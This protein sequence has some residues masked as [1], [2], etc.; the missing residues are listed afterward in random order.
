MENNKCYKCGSMDE[1]FINAEST[2]QTNNRYVCE[3]C[4]VAG[5]LPTICIADMV[6]GAVP[7]TVY[8]I[9]V[10]L[11]K[12]TKK[13]IINA[14]RKLPIPDN[15]PAI[16][17]IFDHDPMTIKQHLEYL[18]VAGYRVIYQLVK[19]TYK[20]F[21]GEDAIKEFEEDDEYTMGVY[22]E[23][24]WFGLLPQQ[25]GAEAEKAA[26]ERSMCEFFKE[27]DEYGY[28]MISSLACIIDFHG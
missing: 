15:I 16:P 20:E 25:A 1:L 27:R 28:P 4:C 3:D 19:Y 21:Y 8:N 9:L 7:E 24:N 18:D 14:I 5:K 22:V 13:Q 17:S 6:E 2:S 11:K 12:K 23:L 26:V 10:N